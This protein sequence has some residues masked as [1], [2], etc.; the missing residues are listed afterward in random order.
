MQVTVQNVFMLVRDEGLVL[1]VALDGDGELGELIDE[2]ELPEEPEVWDCWDVK[3]DGDDADEPEV[4]DLA[5]V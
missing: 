3:E 5:E 2:G 4:K 1:E